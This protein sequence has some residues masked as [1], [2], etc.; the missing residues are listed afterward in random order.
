LLDD[1]HRIVIA[2]FGS[3][4]EYERDITQ[5][6]NV[7]TPLYRAPE[8]SGGKYDQKVDVYS[9]GLL[10][11][12]IVVGGGVFSSPEGYTYAY[13]VI[14]RKERPPIPATVLPGVRDLIER[15]WSENP[16]QRPS[17]DEI[18][19]ELMMMDYVI[20]EGVNSAQVRYLI[21]GLEEEAR[22]RKL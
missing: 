8:A 20:V 19:R 18:E 10:L 5:T 22:T 11:Y 4:R 2:D 14:R 1:D 7:G 6:E 21:E 13:E 9:F 17:F 12:E 3:S 15:C 16:H